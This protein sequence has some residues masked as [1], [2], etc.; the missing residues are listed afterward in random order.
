M[1][2]TEDTNETTESG[3]F[4]EPSDEVKRRNRI[5]GLI[6][7]AIILGMIATAMLVRVYGS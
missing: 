6:I 5:T 3:A 4:T 2:T 1:M 7:T